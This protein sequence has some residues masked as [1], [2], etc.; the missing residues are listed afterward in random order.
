MFYKKKSI[1]DRILKK[2]EKDI[3]T[4]CWRWTGATI[5][6]GYGKINIEG[7]TLLT[8]RVSWEVFNNKKIPQNDLVLHKCDNG[9]CVNPDHLFLG[10]HKDNTQDMMQ[11]KRTKFIGLMD[12]IRDE[13]YQTTKLTN[14]QVRFIRKNLH[15]AAVDLAVEFDVHPKTIYSA[16]SGKTFKDVM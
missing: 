6:K 8:H 3:H 10:N 1:T 4:G 16:R 2:V 5:N 12:R 13:T 11:K 15:I 7:K 9:M 14:E